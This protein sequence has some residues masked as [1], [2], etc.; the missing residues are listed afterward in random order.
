MLGRPDAVEAH[1]TALRALEPPPAVARL[2]AVEQ[3]KAMV[4]GR[5]WQRLVE[6][7]GG[8]ELEEFGE[9][10]PVAELWYARARMELGDVIGGLTATATALERPHALTVV[11]LVQLHLVAATALSGDLEGTDDG[12]AS[13]TAGLGPVRDVAV[14][15]WRGRCLLA[16]GE[17]EAARA[18]FGAAREAADRTSANQWQTAIAE[19]LH[20]LDAPPAGA[21]AVDVTAYRR[22]VLAVHERVASLL[23]SSALVARGPAVVTK[24]LMA[25]L[26]IVWVGQELKGGSTAGEVLVSTGALVPRLVLDGQAW[27]LVSSVLLHATLLHLVFNVLGL[28]LFG[29]TVER[30]LGRGPFFGLFIV[31]GVAGNL[32]GLLPVRDMIG[33]G[34]S[35]GVMGI[36]GA[37]LVL[38]YFETWRGLEEVRRRY[39]R[40]LAILLAINLG[41]GHVEAQVFNGA[42]IGGL[43]AGAMLALPFVSRWQ[44]ARWRPIVAVLLTTVGTLLL[45]WGAWGMAPGWLQREPL[46]PMVRRPVPGSSTTVE[47]PAGWPTL[48]DG[49]DALLVGT[50]DRTLVFLTPLPD[51]PDGVDV[52]EAT[53]VLARETVNEMTK[54][55]YTV[56][57]MMRLDDGTVR[58][59]GSHDDAAFVVEVKVV[60]VG[61]SWIYGRLS[62]PPDRLS[63]RHPTFL[64]M[65]RS[66]R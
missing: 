21:P 10:R 50:D 49:T 9:L 26:V 40:D 23:Q 44:H 48:D 8:L 4:Y 18:A 17:I 56:E 2:V 24:L 36:L 12:L 64:Q 16:R 11:P 27:R 41:I 35:G 29:P 33:V 34:A 65:M 62:T 52:A 15:Y 63:R 47:I 61:S 5:R 3:L 59:A 46:V 7:Y 13:L 60:R 66:L 55:A 31:S 38:L 58:W 30:R 20:E 57:P 39:L 28:H 45:A 19:R 25:F 51:L 53:V 32:A 6:L 54:R 42:H 37:T 22:A 14:P 1:F 43:V